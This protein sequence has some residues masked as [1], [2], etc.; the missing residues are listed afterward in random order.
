MKV[1]PHEIPCPGPAADLAARLQAMLPVLTTER[2][3]LRA[4]RLEDFDCYA[5]IVAGPG[6]RFLVDA[7]SREAAWADFMQLTATWLLRGHG[8]WTLVR[9]TDDTAAGFVLIGFEPGDQEPELGYMLHPE[10]TGEGLAV[11]ACRAVLDHARDA[12]GMTRLVSYVSEA[13]ERSAALARR[14][15]ARRDPAAE[16]ALPPE[17]R[18]H[19]HAFRH[20]LTGESLR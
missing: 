8:A 2:L 12:F 11:E 1:A 19:T 6:G 10:A 3:T 14:L 4:P 16:A 20:D 9:R 7:P 17:D 15:G 18:L 13:N 5:Q